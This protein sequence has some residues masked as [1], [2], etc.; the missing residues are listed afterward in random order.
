MEKELRRRRWIV[1]KRIQGWT[2]QEISR[3]LRINKRT[4][5]RWWQTYQSQGF[6]GLG[7]KSREPHTVHRTPE[8]IV[9]QVLDIR[10][11]HGYGPDKIA[12]MLRN[13]GVN[14]GHNTAYRIIRANGLNNPITKPRRVMGKTRFERTHS[15]S[16]WQADFKQTDEDDYMIS[17]LDDHSRFIVGSRI[18][19]TENSE[20]AL[21]LL[22]KCIRYFSCPIQ[23]LTDRGA[24]FWNN[25][26]DVPTA[27]TQFCIDNKIDHIVA[28]VRRPTTTGKVERWHRT[29][30]EEHHKFQNHKRFVRYY[31][32]KRPH[33]ALG[34]KVPAEVYFKDLRVTD[35]VG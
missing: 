7:I 2:N 20:D 21:S 25:R 9:R 35:V 1:H 30:D 3:H 11:G 5:Q 31:N 8:S 12:G 23:I 26:G 15:N 16:L 17:F 13:K 14:I 24:Q 28:S 33:Q 29:F 19:E 6:K 32:Y 10:K 34:Y 4:V 18:N 22:E 27:F